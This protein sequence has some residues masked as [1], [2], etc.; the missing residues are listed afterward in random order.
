MFALVCGIMGLKAL[1]V[2]PKPV[3]KKV[4]AKITMLIILVYLQ[5]VYEV[6][7][8]MQRHAWSI[9]T[10]HQF[11]VGD[12]QDGESV[13]SPGGAARLLAVAVGRKR[14]RLSLQFSDLTF[15]FGRGPGA[16][17]ADGIREPLL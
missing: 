7:A 16:E 2:N 4:Y 12:G 1:L 15:A 9:R 3:H 5:G 17:F 14:R 6:K 10:T 13:I 8:T 11:S